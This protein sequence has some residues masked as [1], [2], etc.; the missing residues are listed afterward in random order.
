MSIRQTLL[1]AAIVAILSACGGGGG[2]SGTSAAQTTLQADSTAQSASAASTILTDGTYQFFDSPMS[3]VP[4]YGRTYLDAGNIVQ[5]VYTMSNSAWLAASDAALMELGSAGW[6][7]RAAGAITWIANADGQSGTL[8]SSIS[9]GHETLALSATD[10]SAQPMLNYVAGATAGAVFPAGAKSYTLSV[11][12]L[13]EEYSLDTAGQGWVGD[14]AHNNSVVSIANL[15]QLVSAYSTGV[16]TGTANG[17]PFSNQ[18]SGYVDGFQDVKFQFAHSTASG[19]DVLFYDNYVHLGGNL[20]GS[21]TYVR[22]TVNGVDLMYIAT[23]PNAVTRYSSQWNPNNPL[24]NGYPLW[25]A[26]NGQV[27]S[28]SHQA[29]GA[30][31]VNSAFLNKIALNA[32]LASRKLPAVLD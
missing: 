23:V 4:I 17:T 28:G 22:K 13:G 32:A 3:P 1:A 5:K 12:A 26:F 11:T 10:I 14:V 7:S 19:G 29:S 8:T 18:Y 20:L 24:F 25:S 30:V 21:G 31:G 2:G 27:F 16:W 15:D 6:T 9:G